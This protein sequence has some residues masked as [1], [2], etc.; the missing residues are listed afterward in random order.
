[1]TPEGPVQGPTAVLPPYSRKTFNVADT[2]P[3]EFEVSTEVRSSLPVVAE[4]STYGDERTWAHS[5]V[6]V[7]AN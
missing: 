7:S 3:S 2:V 1:M 4:R 5:S 6:G